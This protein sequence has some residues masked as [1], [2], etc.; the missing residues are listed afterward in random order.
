MSQRAN[1]TKQRTRQEK[2]VFLVNAANVLVEKLEKGAEKTQVQY[3]ID[4]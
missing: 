3:L 2:G 1:R 4:D